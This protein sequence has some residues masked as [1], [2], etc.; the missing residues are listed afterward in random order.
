MIVWTI[1]LCRWLLPTPAPPVRKLWK[2][3][4][5]PH[6]CDKIIFVHQWTMDSW[7]WDCLVLSERRWLYHSDHS[8]LAV[9]NSISCGIKPKS[10]FTDDKLLLWSKRFLTDIVSVFPQLLSSYSHC[11]CE[12][13]TYSNSL[14]EFQTL[15]YFPLSAE[16][17]SF[18]W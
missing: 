2:G 13:P 17:H 15:Q 3:C 11:C 14:L 18:S 16:F 6:L 8:V 12:E 9:E 7:T 1:A 10:W 4:G 5:W